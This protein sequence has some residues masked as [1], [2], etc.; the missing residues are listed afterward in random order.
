MLRKEKEE[1]N[2]VE[3]LS[4]EDLVPIDHILRKIDSAVDFT[5]IYDFVEDLYCPDN[6]RPSID[7]IVLFKMVL[8]QHVFGIPSLRRTAEEVRLNVA[9]R[10][11]LGYPLSEATPHFSTLSYNFKHRYT[12]ETVDSIFYWIL[13]EINNAGYLAPEAVFVDGTH[14]KANANIK[15]AVKR[16]VPQA[17]KI[18]SEQ[19]MEEINQDRED[20][21]K[22]P[23]DGPQDPEEKTITE[24]TTD[25]E[26]GVFHKGEHKKCFA[27]TAMTAC[28]R[29]GYVMGATVNPG[30]V[31]DSVA[32]DGLYEQITKKYPN[33]RECVMDAGFKTP[34]ICKKV[35]DDNRIP[36]LP[37]KRPMGNSNFFRPYSYVYDEYYDCVICPQNHVLSYSTTNREGYREFKSKSY[38]C[39]DCPSKAHCTNNSKSEKLVTKH[40]WSDYLEIAE[41]IRHTPEYKALYDKRKETIER[42][43]ADAKEKHAMRYTLYR[44]LTNVTNWVRLKF[45]AM[46][47]KKYA[48][49]RWRRG[50]ASLLIWRFDFVFR[51]YM[52]LTPGFVGVRGFSTNCDFD[53][54]CVEVGF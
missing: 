47:L 49:H 11:F 25:P 8:I 14:I 42:V 1:R 50:I 33:I 32:F 13:D 17:A 12:K 27:Y 5:H 18:Y 7:P 2:Q 39:K 24:S 31:H 22:K 4:L 54:T 45:A 21:G 15:K 53:T 23:F 46:N 10:W 48:I 44:G 43:F 28:D 38:I 26:S 30:N 34:W 6:G 36:V 3:F 29:N 9:Y 37:Y 16:A 52:I 20:H 40:I 35:I 41:D 51:F 19:L